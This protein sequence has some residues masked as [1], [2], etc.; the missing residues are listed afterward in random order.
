MKLFKF[1]L[2][3]IF[4]LT[5]LIFRA[6]GQDTLYS[7][8][9]LNLA[10]K[11]NLFL[12]NQSLNIDVSKGEYLQVKNFFPG[13]PGLDIDYE[14]D[15]YTSNTGGYALGITFSQ[16]LE[17]GGQFSLRKDIANYRIKKS[18]LDYKTA[19]AEMN[20]K[21]KS[22]INSLTFLQ[23]KF[24]IAEEIY[25]LNNELLN[26]ADRRLKAGDISQLDYNLVLIERN[27]SLTN[28]NL[29]ETQF[30]NEMNNLNYFVGNEPGTVFYLHVDTAFKD[31]S[32]SLEQLKTTALTGRSDIRAINYEILANESE[33]SLFYRE[34]IPNLKLSLGYIKDRNLTLH[35]DIIG[36]NNISS[37]DDRNR[38]LKFGV[39]ISLL[40]PFSGLYNYN[41]GNISIAEVRRKILTNEKIL[42]EKE[43]TTDLI[44]SYNKFIR[45]KASIQLL[46]DNNA[47]I[48][49]SLGL[50]QTGYE[51][52]E[53]SL[54]NYLTEK[55]KLYDFKLKYLE[56]LEDYNQSLIELERITQTKLY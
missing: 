54:I 32:L 30:K 36:P 3:S 20:F 56:V 45:T 4:L 40:L 43:I 48:D 34:R 46:K 52:G 19:L 16:E 12:R 2:I 53:I 35:D 15:K 13:S 55:Q 10:M 6:Y 8:Q 17:I 22:I 9:I 23:L 33:L 41:Q 26:A 51:K 28:L 38:S 47:I 25:R 1:S 49:N 44:N 7:G 18:E 11:N 42:K 37:I 21:I 27:N 31:F 5:A 39:G 50:L 14:T 24:Q 29:N